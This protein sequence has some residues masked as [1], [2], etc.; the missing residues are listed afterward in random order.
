MADRAVS[1]DVEVIFGTDVVGNGN[2]EHLPGDI[3]SRH[4]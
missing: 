4:L 1:F 2:H 3:D